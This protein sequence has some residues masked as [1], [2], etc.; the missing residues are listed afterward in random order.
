MTLRYIWNWYYDIWD[1][2]K[3]NPDTLMLKV[4]WMEEF[5]VEE[6]PKWFNEQAGKLIDVINW[7]LSYKKA[8]PNFA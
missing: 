5:K 3:Y 4:E 2:M 6:N 7:E 8:F 1:W